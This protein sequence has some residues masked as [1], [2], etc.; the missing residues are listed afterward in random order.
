VNTVID[1]R[2]RRDFSLYH[3]RK[4]TPLSSTAGGWRHSPNYLH[5]QATTM[6]IGITHCHLAGNEW[7]IEL[8]A[9]CWGNVCQ[10]RLS[11]EAQFR[12]KMP[13]HM[14]HNS[15]PS[16]YFTCCTSLLLHFISLSLSLPTFVQWPSWDLY[17]S[18][19][20]IVTNRSYLYEINWKNKE[21]KLSYGRIWGSQG[22]EYEDGCLLG[23][24][25]V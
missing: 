6:F 2:F 5:F 12:I 21:I 25:A 7:Q 20:C 15:C 8:L 3:V 13:K 14:T 22:G 18:H 9:C 1:F 4:V 24:S 17:S 10:I 19:Q 23:C 16:V 11:N